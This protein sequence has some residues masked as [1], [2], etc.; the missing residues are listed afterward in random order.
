MTAD[1]RRRH[2]GAHPPQEGPRSRAART[3]RAVRL[4]D[5]FLGEEAPPPRAFRSAA[6]ERAAPPAIAYSPK[7]TPPRSPVGGQV[8]RKSLLEALR[9]YRDA[10]GT[11]ISAPAGY[12]KT[13]LLTQLLAQARERGRLAC[14]YTLDST[15]GDAATLLQGLVGAVAAHRPGFGEAVCRLLNDAVSADAVSGPGV[16]RANGGNVGPAAS[17]FLE[18]LHAALQTRWTGGLLL[19][20]DDCHTVADSAASAALLDTLLSMAPERCHVVLSGR[21]LPEL[22]SR[23][24]LEAQRQLL[25][26]HQE[27]LAL[28]R[29]ETAELVAAL[30]GR[31][32]LEEDEDADDLW[33]QTGGWPMAAALLAAHTGG[34]NGRPKVDGGEL[35]GRVEEVL[36]TFLAADVLE[37]LSPDLRTFALGASVLPYVDVASAGRLLGL[38]P[39]EVRWALEACATRSLFL[40][41]LD[42]P[43]GP[44][45]LASGEADTY[46]FH[47]LFR[48]FLQE[49]LREEQPVRFRWLQRRASALA[50]AAGDVPRAVEHALAARLYQRASRLIQ[51]AFEILAAREQWEALRRWLDQ[52]P[53]GVIESAP[54]LLVTAARVYVCANSPVG[55]DR[56]LGRAERLLP[57]ASVESIEASLVRAT[58]LQMRGEYRAA[59][60]LLQDRLCHLGEDAPPMLRVRAHFQMANELARLGELPEAVDLF[61]RARDI[62]RQAG[63]GAWEAT[64]LEGAGVA[65]LRRGRLAQARSAL[66]R[67]DAFWHRSQNRWA[68][69]RTLNNLGLAEHYVGDFAAARRAFQRAVRTAHSA[70]YP[71]LEGCAWLSLGDVL[72]DQDELAAAE[73]AYERG[74]A[75]VRSVSSQYL[76]RYAT[77]AIGQIHRLCGRLD[78]AEALSREASLEAQS[79]GAKQETGR[80][81]RSLALVLFARREDDAARRTLDDAIAQLQGASAD[82]D[83]A[84]AYLTH[85]QVAHATRRFAD[86]RQDLSMLEA[87]LA[88]LGYYGFLLADARRSLAVLDY[89]IARGVCGGRLRALRDAVVAQL[90]DAPSAGHVPSAAPASVL[91]LSDLPP[92]ERV[93]TLRAWSLGHSRVECLADA[94]TSRAWRGDKSREIILYLLCHSG[95][96][97]RERIQADVWM[98]AN[99][100]Q[101]RHAFHSAIYRLRRTLGA[102]LIEEDQG[103]YR[104]NPTA[105]VWFDAAEF[106]HRGQA[107]RESLGSPAVLKEAYGVLDLY[108][109]AFLED[110]SPEWAQPTRNRLE[111]LY[112]DLCVRLAAAL[113]EDGQPAAAE[114]AARRALA[115]DSELEEASALLA[116]SAAEIGRV[117]VT[118]APSCRS[119][120]RLKREVSGADLRAAQPAGAGRMPALG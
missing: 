4:P 62:A 77:D 63:D 102:E 38:P 90:L 85:A 99:E 117:L 35:P 60:N 83:L 87:L 88:Q 1:V 111:D 39:A 75:L 106:E 2:P 109:G 80:Y 43:G 13:T 70:G 53:D 113:L 61:E 7:R 42:A 55:D 73:D 37:A 20:L 23:A 84:Q 118:A 110:M 22:P 40:A 32:V 82:R 3:A 49:R 21:A 33:R 14:W 11:L 52:L 68:Q 93:L 95:W 100:T 19:I 86:V 115:V 25:V 18:E 104:I 48:D 41:H 108:R 8:P 44:G 47:D 9:T 72:R 64:A 46:R 98:E 31:S 12:G 54:R 76:Q 29:R 17:L 26:I 94:R 92:G 69:A 36:F 114:A 105:T 91:G 59:A 58:L 15:D 89:G 27:A 5:T 120:D 101:A 6:Q 34:R 71:G 97:R 74:L 24:R 107:V 28:T 67:A 116:R 78:Q 66:R 30:E 65:E 16:S 56:W 10:H 119:A 51:D 103:R 112:L 57:A 81:L 50:E 45:Q 96:Q 79:A